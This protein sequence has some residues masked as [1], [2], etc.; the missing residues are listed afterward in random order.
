MGK[1]DSGGVFVTC[2]PVFPLVC[3]G[4]LVCLSVCSAV[5]GHDA[6]RHDKSCVFL[7]IPTYLS[8]VHAYM[9]LL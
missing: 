8:G 9:R 4:L 6:V 7:S 3:P 1:S 5:S 2:F